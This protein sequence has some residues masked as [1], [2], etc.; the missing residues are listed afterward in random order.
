[1]GYVLIISGF[2]SYL[3]AESKSCC[4][5]VYLIGLIFFISCFFFY[6]IHFLY[7]NKLCIYPII[8]HGE[9][10]KVTAFSLLILKSL[11]IYVYSRCSSIISIIF[12]SA[13]HDSCIF[14]ILVFSL[15][16][17]VGLYYKIINQGK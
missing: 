17:F 10:D 15:K 9:H 12:L 5:S 14:I 6:Y 13:N 3:R 7:S 4:L 1:M 16:S 11:P 8:Y 2:Y